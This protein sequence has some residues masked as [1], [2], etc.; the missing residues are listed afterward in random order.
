MH[1]HLPHGNEPIK[2]PKVD[3]AFHLL[4]S[5]L[6]LHTHKYTPKMFANS[7]RAGT[8]LSPSELPC[9]RH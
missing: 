7:I 5:R 8:S 6:Y 2:L 4:S 3:F 9:M 1:D